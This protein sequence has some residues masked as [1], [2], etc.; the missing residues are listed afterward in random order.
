[1]TVDDDLPPLPKAANKRRQQRP[2]GGYCIVPAY[3]EEEMKSYAR[4]SVELERW[5]WLKE[6]TPG[7]RR[8]GSVSGPVDPPIRPCVAEAKDCDGNRSSD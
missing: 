3:T 5:R 2:N 7:L 4:L 8:P 1:M 6:D